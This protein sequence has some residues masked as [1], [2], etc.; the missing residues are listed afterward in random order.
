MDYFKVHQTEATEHCDIT[1]VKYTNSETLNPVLEDKIRSYGDV[2]KHASNVKADMTDFT[3]YNDPDFARIC[4]F[5]IMQCINSIE[6]LDPRGASMLRFDV[7]DCWGMVYKNNSQHHTLEHAHWPATFSFCYYVNACENCSP[8]EFTTANYSVKPF[9]GLMVIFPGNVSH[10]VG[11]QNCNHDRVA[12][13]G[14]ISVTVRK[15]G[16]VN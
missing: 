2:I 12:I 9:S 3:M 8:L 16:E 4:N 1:L 13:S 6:G 7:I 15:P 11:I 10:K 5:A 14:N